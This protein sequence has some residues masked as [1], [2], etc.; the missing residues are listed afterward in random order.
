MDPSALLRRSS[1]NGNESAPLESSMGVGGIECGVCGVDED[2]DESARNFASAV[3]YSSSRNLRIR[4]VMLVMTSSGRCTSGGVSVTTGG[5]HG[6]FNHAA[7]AEPG[8]RRARAPIPRPARQSRPVQSKS[9]LPPPSPVPRPH[10]V[11]KNSALTQPR[12]SSSSTHAPF[13]P[14]SCKP[15]PTASTCSNSFSKLVIVAPPTTSLSSLT[16]SIA[17]VLEPTSCL[18]A[19]GWESAAS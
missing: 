1:A 14:L 11:P 3:A 15:L 18:C 7:A 19:Q 12:R 4:R 9:P 8:S 10:P 6:C 2:E 13:G 17:T 5:R 16:T